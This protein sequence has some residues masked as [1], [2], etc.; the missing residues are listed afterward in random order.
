MVVGINNYYSAYSKTECNFSESKVQQT[1][2]KYRKLRN[3][4]VGMIRLAKKRFYGTLNISNT[5]QFWKAY[6]VVNKEFNS[7]S[8]PTLVQG[9][10]EASTD[11]QKADLLNAFFSSCWNMSNS[12]LSSVSP[13][14]HSFMD[15]PAYSGLFFAVKK[16]CLG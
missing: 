1:D 15:D 2:F 6:K 13:S 5:E 11:K 9:D 14:Q 8:I 4:V 7:N 10:T 12:P 3:K 16:K